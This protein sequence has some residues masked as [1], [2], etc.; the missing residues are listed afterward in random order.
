MRQRI[1]VRSRAARV[2]RW[3]MALAPLFPCALVA[4]PHPSAAQLVQ[5]RLRDVE[6]GA[7]V[8][9]ALVLLLD[10]TGA[11]EGGALSGQ[12][13]LFRIRAP[14]PGR[15]TVSAE[16][17][18]FETAVS[19]PFDVDAGRGIEL[20]LDL[21]PKALALEGIRVEAGRRCSV[22][23]EEGRIVAELWDEA[24]KALRNQQW[25]DSVGVVRFRVVEYERN[26]DPGTGLATGETRRSVNWVGRNPIRSRPAQELLEDGFIRPDGTGGYQYFGADAGVLLSDRFL[27]THCFGLTSSGT[28]PDAMGLTFEPL[29][30]RRGMADIEGVLWLGIADVRLRALEFVYT[31]SPWTEAAGV[32]NGRV[33]F[34][35][36]PEGVW[37]VRRWWIRMPRMTQSYDLMRGGQSGL[38]VAGLV[39][40]GGAATRVDVAAGR[41]ASAVAGVLGR[42]AGLVW[43][44]TRAEP[45]GG[46]EVFLSDAERSVISDEAGRFALDSVRVGT[47]ELEFRH[48]RLD[49][50]PVVMPATEV[51]VAGGATAEVTLAV[52]S[53]ASIVGALCGGGEHAP[54]SAAVFGVVRERGGGEPVAGATVLLEWTDYR[55]V[56]GRE[57]LA[58]VQTLSVTTDERGRFT[59]CG[60]PPGVLLAAQA[61]V[62]G[63]FGPIRRVEVPWGEV[64][65]LDLGLDP[66]VSTE[67]AELDVC[68]SMEL[69]DAAG[70]VVGRVLEQATGVPVG[71]STVWLTSDEPGP[72]VSVRSDAAGRFVFCGVQPGAYALRAAVQGLGSGR[73]AVDVRAGGRTDAELRLGAEEAA[74]TTGAIQ[75]RVVAAV[76]GRPLAGAEI[77]LRGRLARISEKDG[78]FSFPEV[79]TGTATV[80]ASAFGYAEAS[81]EVVIGGGQTLTIEVRLSERP[82]E[83]DP[84]VVEAVRSRTG[85]ILED[86][87]RRAASPWGTVL[88]GETLEPRLRTASR[89]TDLLRDQGVTIL[90]NGN[91]LYFNRTRCAPHVF[92]D[93]VKITRVP[94]GGGPIPPKGLEP[95][96]EEAAR[97]LNM[98][99][100]TTIAAVEIYRGPAETPGEFL[101]SDARCGVILI[102]T[103]RAEGVGKED[104]LPR[105]P[106]PSSGPG[107]T[108]PFRRPS[109]W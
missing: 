54:G 40:A 101:D 35:E 97:A 109:D 29:G 66:G 37:I 104:L 43:D 90:S 28:A 32:A 3:G 17:I 38:R 9:G 12:D 10:A 39:E 51:S 27:D 26:V 24:R 93:G 103:R 58:D 52:P 77:R 16:R 100:P 69:S 36:L 55:V 89:T 50:L 82:I 30:S 74:S 105:G 72:T 73:A 19:T 14:R 86:V 41:R 5:G 80:T 62:G 49:S 68:P 107:A 23:P 20:T 63:E 106:P 92:V 53:P 88:I 64:V 108:F 87:R 1:V 6:S 79:S 13:G 57:V 2:A 47:R 61:S 81:G 75:G 46:A 99:D 71:L 65:V 60:V 8:K 70:A 11:Q 94:R 34:E 85:G 56:A 48:P 76:D 22:S 84:I 7:P 44:S 42:I 91:A 95:P 21:E 102:W 96:D 15:Y 59:A 98:V 18:G 4:T 67:E 45:L 33:E 78:S 31:W 25:T 83:L